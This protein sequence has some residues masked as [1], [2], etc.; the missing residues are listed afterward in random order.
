MNPH[1]NFNILLLPFYFF[2]I[3]V[4][5]V[6]VLARLDWKKYEVIIFYSIGI[7]GDAM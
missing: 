6:N 5:L 3:S 4:A 7:T 1:L 2:E